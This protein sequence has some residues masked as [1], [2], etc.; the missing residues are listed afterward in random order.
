M[1]KGRQ[2]TKFSIH[3]LL[4]MNALMFGYL[5]YKQNVGGSTPSTPTR[6]KPA[7]TK[8]FSGKPPSQEGTNS[9]KVSQK[10]SQ[11]LGNVSQKP[12]KIVSQTP[13]KCFPFQG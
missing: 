13:G 5:P 11:N 4:K 10:V 9:R 1:Q 7:T 3:N 2:I 12:V 8:G 6:S